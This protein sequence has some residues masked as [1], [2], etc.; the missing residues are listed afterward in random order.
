ME[1]S[2]TPTPQTPGYGGDPLADIRR[3]AAEMAGWLK[4]IG[5]FYII[6]GALSAIS[7]AGIIIAWIPIWMG[8]LLFQSGSSA[9]TA[10]GGQRIDELANVVKRLKTYFII[11]GVLVIIFIAFLIVFFLFMMLGIVPFLRDFNQF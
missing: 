3:T 2:I 9:I 5:V 10:Q 4:F 8:V 6:V 11:N 1:E 7:I